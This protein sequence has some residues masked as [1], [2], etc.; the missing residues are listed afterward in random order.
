M[1]KI[2]LI[3]LIVIFIITSTL[4]LT[5]YKTISGNSV[6]T[7]QCSPGDDNCWHD[8]AHQTLNGEYCDMIKDNEIK[9]YCVEYFK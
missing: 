5:L 2:D 8:L 9:G 7:E 4:I 6:S 3:A 1:K